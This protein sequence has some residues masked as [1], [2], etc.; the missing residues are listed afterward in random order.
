MKDINYY[1]DIGVPY[2]KKEDY[3]Y[4][5]VNNVQ[6]GT[7]LHD[8]IFAEDLKNMGLKPVS[9][10]KE[11]ELQKLDGVEYLVLYRIAE[12]SYERALRFYINK[13]NELIKEF[14]DDLAISEN[15]EPNSRMANIIYCEAYERGHSSGLSEVANYYSGIAYFAQEVINAHKEEK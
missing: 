8:K 3:S 9:E 6:E 2:P 1:K 5:Q 11:A 12:D 10:I 13:S 7:V 14:Q 15:L 4:Y